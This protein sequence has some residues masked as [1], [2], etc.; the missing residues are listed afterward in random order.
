[1][2]NIGIELGTGSI[3]AAANAVDV[4]FG[5]NEHATFPIADEA[6]HCHARDISLEI[7]TTV[8]YTFEYIVNLAPLSVVK[9]DIPVIGVIG[10]GEI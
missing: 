1:M 7:R 10:V 3:D 4:G 5:D 8:I 9:G 6:I 2:I